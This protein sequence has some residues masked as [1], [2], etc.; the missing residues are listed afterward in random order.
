[1]SVLG[2]ASPVR[3]VVNRRSAL[4]ALALLAVAGCGG[5]VVAGEPHWDYDAEG[6]DHWADLDRGYATCRAGHAQS[7]IAL[8]SPTEIHPTDHIEV[9]YRPVSA[10]TLLNNGHTIQASVPA[11]SGNAIVVDGTRFTLTQFHFHLPSEHTVDG[12]EAAMELHLVHTAP[13]GRLAV[14]AVLLRAAD[15]PTPLSRVLA[16]SPA[17]PGRTEAVAA[18]DPREFLPVDLAQ[19]RYQGSLT[20][21]PC[22]EGVE[23][24]VL[25]HSTAVSVTDIDNYRAMFP[26]SNRP[27]QPRYGRPVVLAG[28]N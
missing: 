9:D 7:P 21:P 25:R 5:S 14:L 26:H 2:S 20:T 22:T 27:T 19:F 6:P 11:E 17:H 13:S 16:A 23:W 3:S 1:M 15:D 4:V 12:D 28:G 10:V 24:T 8:D 18:V